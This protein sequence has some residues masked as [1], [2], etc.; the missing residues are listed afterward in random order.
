MVM[1]VLGEGLCWTALCVLP[2]S[3]ELTAAVMFG[4]R[5]P[6]CRSRGNSL[7][8]SCL[9]VWSRPLR[10]C[11]VESTGVSSLFKLVMLDTLTVEAMNRYEQGEQKGRLQSNT[12]LWGGIGGMLGNLAGGLGLSYWPHFAFKEM[13]SFRVGLIAIE[14][15]I[16][17]QIDD[18]KTPR[19]KKCTDH[20]RS[21]AQTIWE[22]MHEARVWRPMVFVCVFHCFPN[23]SDAFNSFLLGDP[24]QWNRTAAA[25]WPAGVAPLHFSSSQFGNVNFMS[26]VGSIVGI[27]LYKTY[28]HLAPWRPL[29]ALTILFSSMISLTQLLLISGWSSR[30][31]IPAIAFALGDDL[32]A[33]MAGGFMSMP[34][35]VLMGQIVPAGAEGSVFA[36]VTSLRAM[37]TGVSGTLSAILTAALGVSLDDFSNL[38]W[39]TAITGLARLLAIPFVLL[40]P[41]NILDAKTRTSRSRGGAL[42][43]L[44]GLV[45]GTLWAV[46]TAL[47]RLT[48]NNF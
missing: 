45:G 5:E 40:V 12:W 20:T 39:L 16:M 35:W 28:F 17:S 43:L 22:T 15:L 29:F 27:Y 32:V 13:F 2:S 26:M 33:E 48:G 8:V 4:Q 21:Q 36:L 3:I 1:G 11:N 37:G 31:G 19:E 47:N 14:L 23:N 6:P 10:V 25:D 41:L 30:M 46:A 44:I 38:W 7:Y 9:L 34:L 24:Q 42:A 18:P